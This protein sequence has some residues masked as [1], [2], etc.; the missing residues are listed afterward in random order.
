SDGSIHRFDTS[1]D[2]LWSTNL[3]GAHTRMVDVDSPPVGYKDLVIA[4]SHS[5]GV[6]ALNQDTGR[7]VWSLDKPGVQTPLLV[8][9]TLILTTTH[10]H[11]LWMDA[12]DGTV[13]HDLKLAQPGLTA[14]IRFTKNSFVVGDSGRGALVLS[15]HTPRITG[16]F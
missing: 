7:I 16:F 3:A 4:V 8:G 11:V 15:I 6:Y 10:G 13:R 5:G 2:S 1:G 14:P 12:A 9:N